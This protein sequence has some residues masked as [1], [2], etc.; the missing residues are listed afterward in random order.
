MPKDPRYRFPGTGHF[1]RTLAAER[2]DPLLESVL[3]TIRP[4]SIALSHISN[5]AE[6]SDDATA[7]DLLKRA[8]AQV[9]S[10]QAAI[11]VIE[12]AGQE[13]VKARNLDGMPQGDA[14]DQAPQERLAGL[15][16]PTDPQPIVPRKRGPRPPG[17]RTADMDFQD[18]GVR[19]SIFGTPADGGP[20]RTTLQI[21]PETT[22][23]RSA[24]GRP[25]DDR[26]LAAGS[27]AEDLTAPV[28]DTTGRNTESPAPGNQTGVD[29]SPP[30]EA[31]GAATGT[32]PTPAAPSTPN[33]RRRGGNT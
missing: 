9:G 22:E 4:L 2:S 7:E 20:P 32:A 21:A 31:E 29:V 14:K 8:A 16:G 23:L 24:P 13:V 17:V 5:A 6:A 15:I 18:T 26:T 28:E 30:N 27:I 3:A 12:R 25:E 11:E 33:T 10:L 19:T 1:V